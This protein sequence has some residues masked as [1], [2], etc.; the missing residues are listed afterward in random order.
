MLLSQERVLAQRGSSRI[1]K[2][3]ELNSSNV[4]LA[5]YGIN[6]T[7]LPLYTG[8]SSVPEGTTITEKR[9]A[10]DTL[11]LDAGN[12]IIERCWINPS[13][14]NPGNPFATTGDEP[15]ITPTR[16]IIRDC[17]FDGTAL[18]TEESAF[19]VGFWGIADVINCHFYG[20]GGGFAIVNAENTLSCVIENNYVHA[21]TATGEPPFNNHA[22]SFSIRDFEDAPGRTCYVR[23]N[24]FMCDAGEG[25]DTGAL[26][27]QTNNG[28]I[29]NVLIEGNLLEGG[30]YNLG[31]ERSAFGLPN[32]YGNLN[33]HNNRLGPPGSHYYDGGPGW[34]SQSENY[35][36]D[37]SAIEGKGTP[38]PS[39]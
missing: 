1:R 31:L 36:Y 39:L 30:G 7:S 19:R 33:I 32:N 34:A 8:P 26:F 13:D 9:I 35:V 6:K 3:W 20:I 25:F 28:N 29:H 24:R 37:S 22:D 2:G 14:P 38:I 18:T 21:H 12:I 4:G 27:I 16:V 11:G 10:V 23:N 5:Y 17:D 15:D